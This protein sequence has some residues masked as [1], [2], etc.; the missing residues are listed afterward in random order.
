MEYYTGMRNELVLHVSAWTSLTNGKSCR[1]V[2]TGWQHLY[3]RYS[4]YVKQTSVMEHP[5]TCD[6]TKT[7][8]GITFTPFSPATSSEA[9]VIRRGYVGGFSIWSI[10]ILHV[11]GRSQCICDSILHIFVYARNSS[12]T[13]VSIQ[14]NK[15]YM[16]QHSKSQKQRWEEKTGCRRI[17]AVQ[18]IYSLRTYKTLLTYCLKTHA[19]VIKAKSNP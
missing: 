19:Y 15:S 11:G 4:R 8:T 5:H 17:Y 14:V 1:T 3:K 7:D 12:K 16:Y 2:N 10:L 13:N 6:D 18:S 9:E